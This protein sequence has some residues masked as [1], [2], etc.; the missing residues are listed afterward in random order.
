EV[1][2]GSLRVDNWI[3]TSR[4]DVELDSKAEKA[5]YSVK[6]V[7]QKPSVRGGGCQGE[8]APSVSRGSAG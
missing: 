1:T 3:L 2:M 5:Y 8:L 6:Q 4:I 7:N